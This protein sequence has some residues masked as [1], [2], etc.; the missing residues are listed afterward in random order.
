MGHEEVDPA[1]PFLSPFLSRLPSVALSLS[2][3]L[4]LSLF[5]STLAFSEGWFLAAAVYFANYRYIYVHLR[6]AAPVFVRV[7]GVIGACVHANACALL[8]T[9]CLSALGEVPKCLP[10]DVHHSILVFASRV[11]PVEKG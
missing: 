8:H 5:F 7:C 10:L 6:W 1:P 9:C 11:A 4:S 2:L 3:S